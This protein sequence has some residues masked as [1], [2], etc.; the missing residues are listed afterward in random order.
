MA[1][2]SGSSPESFELVGDTGFE[3]VAFGFGGG[4]QSSPADASGFQAARA[5]HED[6]LPRVQ[7][8]QPRPAIIKAFATPVLRDDRLLTVDQVAAKLSVSTAT[9]YGLCKRGQ[10]AHIRVSNAIRV[11]P[12]DVASFEMENRR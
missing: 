6:Y 11:A 4:P 10:L 12:Q 9:V 1:P 3:P 5:R 2:N 7:I 8:V